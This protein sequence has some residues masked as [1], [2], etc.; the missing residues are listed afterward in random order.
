MRGKS[1]CLIVM[2]LV[3]FSAFGNQFSIPATGHIAPPTSASTTP[4]DE[5]TKYQCYTRKILWITWDREIM[6]NQTSLW[7]G[8][9][10]IRCT[11]HSDGS[12]SDASVVVGESTGLLKVVSMHSLL[13]TA[14]FKRFNEALLNEV[15]HSYT[16]DFIFTIAQKPHPLDRDWVPGGD[17]HPASSAPLD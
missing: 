15:G 1:I 17:S 3:G 7:F 5:L 9:V 6:Q 16:D 10:K 13:A 8:E 2:A 11:I 14:P 12:V 4:N